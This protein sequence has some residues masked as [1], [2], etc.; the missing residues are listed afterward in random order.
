MSLLQVH[1][2]LF[3]KAAP[4]V[5]LIAFSS[6]SALG[7][8]T[9]TACKALGDN[10]RGRLLDYVKK[11]YKLPQT[12]S[13]KF[14]DESLVSSTCF[15]KIEFKSA[16]PKKSFQ[17]QLFLS[18]DFRFLT[19]ELLD[20]TVDPVLE[21]RQKQQA[22]AAGLT[23]GNFPSQ[24]P[25]DAQVTMTIFSDFQCPYCAQLARMLNKEI[26]PKE[27]KT[28]RVVFRYFPLSM[29]NWARPAAQAAACVQEQG[30]EYFWR[31]HDFLFERQ[32]EFTPDNVVARIGEEA[33][34]FRKFDS[35]RFA[36][37][38]ASKRTE[39]NIARDI[40][41]GTDNGVTGTPTLFRACPASP[42]FAPT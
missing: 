19:S 2:V 39:A 24:G 17:V 34:H 42:C 5:M 26:F 30:D 28:T 11:K 21:E 15:R 38:V 3:S 36:T 35:S 4:A 14:G 12:E 6:M 20:S 25:K 7:A 9:G 31:L 27:G 37:C 16:D 22:L 41:F 8:T 32:H 1:S 40:A 10:Q 29:H 23:K 33:K 13:L 18:P